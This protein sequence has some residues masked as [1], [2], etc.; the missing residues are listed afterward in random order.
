MPEFDYTY[1]GPRFK[2][3]EGFPGYRI[4]TDGSVW[5]SRKRRGTAFYVSDDWKPLRAIPTSSGYPCFNLY[6]NGKVSKLYAHR[7]AL[8]AFIGPPP[9]ALHECAHNDGNR[10]NCILGNLRWATRAENHADKIAHGTTNRGERQ[11]IAILTESK[12][13]EMRARRAAGEKIWRL[14]ADYGVAGQT[15]SQV[16]LRRRWQH[17]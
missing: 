2:S 14:A 1:Y 13:I 9:T 16:C 8:F 4:G 5:S 6:L 10:T 15:A 12:V 11:G 7:L 3:I 17:V